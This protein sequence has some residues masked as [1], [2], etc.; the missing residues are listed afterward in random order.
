MSEALIRPATPEDAPV[1]AMLRYDFRASVAPVAE[2][3][4]AFVDR[5]SAWMAERLAPG[6][7]WRCWVAEERGDIVGHLWLQL[8]EKIPNPVVELE[9]HG[10]ITNA[11]VVERARGSGLGQRLMEAAMACCRAEGVDSVLLWP[12][13]RSRTLYARFGFAVR[14]DV[15]E[16]VL[17]DGRMQA[18][19]ELS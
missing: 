16:A 6:S 7:L 14:D 15:M 5:A 4:E 8:I 18:H 12:T 17:D 11:Y 10:Y 3:R 1:L 9:K 13:P 19:E 2:T